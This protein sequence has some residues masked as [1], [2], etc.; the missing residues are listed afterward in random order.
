MKSPSTRRFLLS[1]LMALTAVACAGAADHTANPD[2]SQA[3]AATAKNDTQS[4]ANAG[5]DPSELIKRFDANKDG[6]L[7]VSELPP[8][9]Q[10]WLG[11]ADTNGDSKLS[12]DELRAHAK[13]MQKEHFARM[14]SNK[15]GALTSDEIGERRW[16][17]L[18]DADANKD[19]K[20]T[21]PELAEAMK[22]G[23]LRPPRGGGWGRGGRGPGGPGQGPGGRGRMMQKLDANQDGALSAE[24]AGA[25]MWAHI[26]VA[27]ADKD[28]KVTFDELRAAKESGKL[29]PMKRRH[30]DDDDG[31]DDDAE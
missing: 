5:P 20:V 3:P 24:E 31:D 8:R 30:G 19:G 21:E 10:K 26:S 23:K 12:A 17:H 15:D 6:V 22:S 9:L 27:D 4:A 16:K 13:Q 1:S 29:A 18:S 2:T 11:K 7:E 25:E 14:D 28:G